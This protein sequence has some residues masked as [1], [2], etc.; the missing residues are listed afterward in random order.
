MI[1]DSSGNIKLKSTTADKEFA[2]EEISAQVLRKLCGDAGSFLGADVK[3][4]R[5]DARSSPP[6][7]ACALSSIRG[8]ST[9]AD[10]VRG[11]RCYSVL[12]RTVI[13]VGHNTSRNE[14]FVTAQAAALSSPTPTALTR[15]G[16]HGQKR[17]PYK[18]LERLTGA[19]SVCVCGAN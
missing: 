2:P 3:K 8:S 10:D 4:V 16:V 13:P 1:G 11:L 14:C 5:H 12:G 17:F 19:R 9:C 6:S 15:L 7:S 18:R